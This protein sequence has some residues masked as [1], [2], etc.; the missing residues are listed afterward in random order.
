MKSIQ[1]CPHF[2]SIVQLEQALETME[3]HLD[4]YESATGTRWLRDAIIE[5]Q[6]AIETLEEECQ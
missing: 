6:L 1:D 4:A 5:L 3:Q 2:I